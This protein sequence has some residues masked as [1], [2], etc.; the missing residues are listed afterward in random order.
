M[1]GRLKN[2][3][4]KKLFSIFGIFLVVSMA[5][6]TA[7]DFSMLCPSKT[8]TNNSEA[9]TNL[10]DNNSN[11]QNSIDSDE[12]QSKKSAEP[13]VK[14]NKNSA[15]EKSESSSQATTERGSTY[16]VISIKTEN[17]SQRAPIKTGNTSQK[18]PIK[19]GNTTGNTTENI[20][21]C[22]G[23]EDGSLDSRSNVDSGSNKES[24]DQNQIVASNTTDNVTNATTNS[25]NSTNLIEAN[26][27]A[28][29]LKQEFNVDVIVTIVTI[30][31]LISKKGDI[32]TGDVVQLFDGEKNYYA[33]FMDVAGN[34]IILRILNSEGK[35][36]D[37]NI[38]F[39]DFLSSYTGIKL[40]LNNSSLISTDELLFDINEITEDDLNVEPGFN[41]IKEFVN[42]W[43]YADYVSAGLGIVGGILLT[44]AF[45]PALVPVAPVIPAL[46]AAPVVAPVMPLVSAVIGTACIATAGVIELTKA[47]MLSMVNDFYNLFT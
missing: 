34:Y 26:Y 30:D 45:L 43:K 27:V 8:S 32:N 14:E 5:P 16:Q 38:L 21:Q 36:T 2:M 47:V 4:F 13:N 9:L 20:T 11:P 28:D 15:K 19:T 46:F 25:T 10:S 44:A 24:S 42:R 31:D 18:A 1:Q 17:N 41:K 12:N 3:D 37:C 23:N 33:I 22:S 6:I 39:D 40:V 7:H 35:F 29:M